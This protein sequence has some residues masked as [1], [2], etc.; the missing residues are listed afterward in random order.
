MR[1]EGRLAKQNDQVLSFGRVIM[2]AV[3]GYL[4]D[5][6]PKYIRDVITVLGLEGAKPVAT[7]SAKRTPTTKSFV[8]MENEQCAEH[9]WE[10]CCTCAKIEQTSC[11]A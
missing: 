3:R 11:A 4:V 5:A 9:P 6:N 7:P 8:E 1:I 2:K 10:N